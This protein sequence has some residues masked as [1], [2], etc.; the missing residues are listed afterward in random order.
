MHAALPKP[1]RIEEVLARVRALIRRAHGHAQPE[2]RAGRVTLDPRRS[3]VTL[4][5]R[6]VTLTGHEYRTPGLRERAG[7]CGNRDERGPSL[8][9]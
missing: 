8:V 5:G 4:D 3:S 7:R 1:F 9:E 2:L 6:P